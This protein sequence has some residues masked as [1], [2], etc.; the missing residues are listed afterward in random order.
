M[1]ALVPFTLLLVA[2]VVWMRLP[3]T[4][5]M[6]KFS[7]FY[8]IFKKT[9]L[10]V[11]QQIDENRYGLV[12][13]GNIQ[14]K[15]TLKTTVRDIFFSSIGKGVG[16]I[17]KGKKTAFL[18]DAQAFL[19]VSPLSFVSL[20]PLIHTISASLSLC[21]FALLSTHTLLTIH[22]PFHADITVLN[23]D[24]FNHDNALDRSHPLSGSHVI[25]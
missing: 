6:T 7:I 21:T 10:F 18:G 20:T 13:I 22:K 15:G 16:I 3:L 4:W 9:I 24:H 5:R 11:L 8:V 2:K 14:E 19:Q 12:R 17:E 23:K 1:W 25:D